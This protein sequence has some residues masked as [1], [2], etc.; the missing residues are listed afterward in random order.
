MY[1]IEGNIGAGKST[2]LKM[3]REYLPDIT[4]ALEP[5]ESW[6]TPI[7]GDSLLERFMRDAPRW[8]FTMETCA[9]MSRVREH[10][11]YQTMDI[12][13]LIVERSVYSGHY[14]FSLNGYHQGFMTPQEWRIYLH[15]FEYL[16]P[17]MCKKPAGFMYLRTTPEI[18]YERVKKRARPSEYS[19]SLEYLQQLHA[20]HEDF[21]ITKRMPLIS[22]IHTVPVLILDCTIDFENNP[23]HMHYLSQQ[24]NT[25]IQ[26]HNIRT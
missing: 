15:Y 11:R 19:L 5:L 23:E 20:C 6:D 22:D 26:E 1:I 13:N 3:L 16:I 8:A 12:S 24:V 17:H 7:Q 14:V 21:L 9:M 2:F 25:F 18:A 10:M 4:T